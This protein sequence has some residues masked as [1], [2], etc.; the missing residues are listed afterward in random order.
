MIRA[1]SLRV[2]LLLFTLSRAAVAANAPFQ[3]VPVDITHE[4]GSFSGKLSISLGGSMNRARAE[5]Q[6]TIR[7]TSPQKIFRA[8]FCVRAFDAAGDQLKPGGEDC[9]LRLW[10]TNWQPDVQL[11]FKGHQDIKI[12]ENRV[13]LQVAKYTITATEVLDHAPNLRTLDVRCPLVWSSALRVFAEQ[14][15]RPTV[16]DKDSLTATFAYDGGRIDRPSEAERMLKAYT[17]AN[18]GFFYKWDSFRIDAASLYLR[19]EAAGGCAA[20]VKMSFAGFGKPFMGSLSWY[21]V[22]SNFNFERALLQQLE[23]QSRQAARVD[24]DKAISR[25]PTETPKAVEGPARPQLTITSDPPGAEIEIDGEFIGN[26]PTTIMTKE[27]SVVVK[28]TKAG[29]QTWERTLK[30]SAGDKRTLSVEMSK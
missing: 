2:M 17:T 7:N 22:D 21:A 10:G 29:F 3:E 14:K 19:D 15:F 26:T 28:V 8:T 9:V 13:P 4:R 6:A 11:S 5:C 1:G 16:L 27:G 23:A 12:S 20:E 25:L 24:L 30:L 18:T